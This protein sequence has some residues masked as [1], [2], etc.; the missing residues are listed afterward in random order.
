MLINEH[1]T[2]NIPQGS[3][4]ARL[5]IETKLIIWNEA[6]MINRFCF[7]AL[8]KTLRDVMRAV[9][10]ENTLKPFRGKVIVLGGDFRQILPVVK[11]GSRYDIVKTTVNYSELWK[12]CKVLKLTKK[13]EIKQ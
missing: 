12:H 9:S 4:H 10:E 2:Y 6:P 5:L 3:F 7:E 8:D 1:S 11:N 13:Y